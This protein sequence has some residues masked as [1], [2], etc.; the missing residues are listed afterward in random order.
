MQL[1]NSM[2]IKRHL[3]LAPG[4]SS[5]TRPALMSSAFFQLRLKAAAAISASVNTIA[6]QLSLT[7]ALQTV[8][9]VSPVLN[10]AAKDTR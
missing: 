1:S 2:K 3:R 4:T 7:F 10:A 9:D 8:I 5:G 6:H